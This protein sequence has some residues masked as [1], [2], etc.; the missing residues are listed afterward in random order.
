MLACFSDDSSDLIAGRCAD[1]GLN[2][3]LNPGLRGFVP[4][5]ESHNA[6]D[7]QQ[8]RQSED[9]LIGEGRAKRGAIVV[10]EI[11]NGLL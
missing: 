6:D 11:A 8:Q 10:Q 5:Y 4:H 3:A 9:R 1:Q 7:H 2:P